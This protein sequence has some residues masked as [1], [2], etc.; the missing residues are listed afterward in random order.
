MGF[1]FV[2]FNLAMRLKSPKCVD[3]TTYVEGLEERKDIAEGSEILSLQ[4]IYAL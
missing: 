3:C 4:S 1:N 2:P